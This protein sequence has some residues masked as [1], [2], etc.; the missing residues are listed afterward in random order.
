[1]TYE[2]VICFET[3]VELKTQS[4]LFCRCPVRYDAAPNSAV[5]PV[6]TG[7]PGTLPVI[8][9]QAVEFALRAGLALHCTVNPNSRFARKNYFYPDLP[10]G[11]QISQYERPLC[12]HGLLEITGDDGLSY[13]VGIRRIH[14]EEDAG[15]L[16]HSSPSFEGSDF[17]LADYNRAGVPLLEI[18]GDHERNPLRSL[19]ESRAYLEK[20]RQILRYIGVSDCTIEKGQF[21]CDVNISLRP[22]GTGGFGQRAEIK[23]MTSFRFI[24]EALEYEIKRQSEILS[25][26]GEVAQETRLFDEK[27]KATVP[28]RSKED[29]PDYRYFPDPDL[30]HVE[31]DEKEVARIRGTLP[32][33]P[34]QKILRLTEQYGIP[35]EDILILTRDREVSE[36]FTTCAALCTDSVRLSRWLVRDLFNLLRESK[37]SIVNCPVHPRDFS[38]LINL[39]A[40]G[41]ITDSMARSMLKEMYERRCSPGSLLTDGAYTPI[42]DGDVLASVIKEVVAENPEA[43]SKVRAGVMEPINFLVGQVMRKTGGKADAKRVRAL[44]QDKLR[45]GLRNSP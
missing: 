19:Q 9:Y 13:A 3:H 17:S 42:R 33:L 44:I 38:E 36:Y 22:K 8:N 40:Q 14:L 43:V 30:V 18:V 32:E 27:S 34:D 29:A 12:E 31:V 37:Q 41:A 5:C 39:L 4:K 24:T 11:Y 28:M 20:L 23:N 25:S 35:R 26:G 16:V 15:K 10:K 7:Q 1:M 45:G 2:P 6:C 21:R